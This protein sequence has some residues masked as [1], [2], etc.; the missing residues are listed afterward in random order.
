MAALQYDKAKAVSSIHHTVEN[1]VPLYK[2]KRKE[3]LTSHKESESYL[4]PHEEEHTDLVTKVNDEAPIYSYK[5]LKQKTLP[6]SQL[7]HS[8]QHHADSQRASHYETVPQIRQL[9]EID[10]H[11]LTQPN[12]NSHTSSLES[13]RHIESDHET[14]AR[15]I[16]QVGVVSQTPLHHGTIASAKSNHETQSNELSKLEL[17]SHTRSHHEILPHIQQNPK[18]AS[19]IQPQPQSYSQTPLYLESV[20]V[21]KSNHEPQPH[22]PSNFEEDSQIPSPHNGFFPILFQNLGEPTGEINH[23]LESSKQSETEFHEKKPSYR[24]LAHSILSHEEEIYKSSQIKPQENIQTPFSSHYTELSPVQSHHEIVPQK[25]SH[26]HANHELQSEHNSVPHVTLRYVNTHPASSD[27]ETGH[28]QPQYDTA[29]QKSSHHNI[30]PH[31]NEQPTLFHHEILSHLQDDLQK[32]L[33]HKPVPLISMQQLN[34][35][36]VPE[37]H[38]PPHQA[39]LQHQSV[40]KPQTPTLNYV[41]EHFIPAHQTTEP[42]LPPLQHINEIQIPSH[43]DIKSVKQSNFEAVPQKSQVIP[44]ISPYESPTEVKPQTSRELDSHIS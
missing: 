34:E 29:P 8:K 15:K 4:I 12:T 1:F 2:E 44:S 19:H 33:S 16:L 20:T 28:K 26:R 40:H 43:H 37:P 39:D 9:H 42:H 36:S 41:T 23:K 17:E 30:V 6:Q 31:V 18:A 5:T 10:H 25:S 21:I 3:N 32:S 27:D 11:K 35:V 13:S 38:I 24:N 7:K 22:K 14:E